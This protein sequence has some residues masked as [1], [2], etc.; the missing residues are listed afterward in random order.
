MGIGGREIVLREKNIER[1]RG[2]EE[3]GRERERRGRE[4]ER[5]EKRERE[6][7]WREGRGWQIGNRGREKKHEVHVGEGNTGGRRRGEGVGRRGGGGNLIRNGD[8]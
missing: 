5:R 6:W 1:E 2:R 7:R 8:G 3:G 4:R